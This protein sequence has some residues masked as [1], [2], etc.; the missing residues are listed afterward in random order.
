MIKIN[1]KTNKKLIAI[2]IKK[3]KVS[4]L[5]KLLIF[6]QILDRVI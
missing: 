6:F 3:V 4:V 5:V 2:T 1:T